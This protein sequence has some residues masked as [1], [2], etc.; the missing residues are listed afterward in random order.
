MFVLV[1][2]VDFYVLITHNSSFQ[3]IPCLSGI[4]INEYRRKTEALI[5]VRRLI[6]TRFHI[7]C[8]GRLF[9]PSILYANRIQH[10]VWKWNKN[11][12]TTFSSQP[13]VVKCPAAHMSSNLLRNTLFLNRRSMCYRMD[14][15]GKN[16]LRGWNC[17]CKRARESVCLCD[18]EYGRVRKDVQK[19]ELT[20]WRQ[21]W[22]CLVG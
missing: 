9:T 5:L 7:E 20:F 8:P 19:S 2:N 1:F 16:N 17:V 10:F 22:K 6:T 11:V 18:S 12:T 21:R 13:T 15:V 4:R 3:Y 14:T